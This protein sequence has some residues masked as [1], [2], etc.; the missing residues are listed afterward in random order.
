MNPEDPRLLQAGSGY[1]SAISY[2]YSSPDTCSTASCLLGLYWKDRGKACIVTAQ[3]Q[4]EGHSGTVGH[5][6]Q[7]VRL[8][9]GLTL[10]GLWRA[11]S[12]HHPGLKSW[13]G[14]DTWSR[15]LHLHSQCTPWHHPDPGPLVGCREVSR[16][17]DDQPPQCTVVSLSLRG[18]EQ[19]GSFPQVRALSSAGSALRFSCEETEV[20]RCSRHLLTIMADRSTV[21][22]EATVAILLQ[23]NVCGSPGWNQKGPGIS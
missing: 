8:E 18:N 10:L 23:A 22:P 21:H 5:S 20:Q 13:F 4:C 11:V 14:L 3:R 12:W 6:L 9:S 7:R 19:E 17:T 15:A 2:H 16:V 1:R